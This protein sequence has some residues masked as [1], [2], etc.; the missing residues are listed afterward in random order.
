[1]PLRRL[2]RSHGLRAARVAELRPEEQEK[3]ENECRQ[4]QP[5]AVAES[6]GQVFPPAHLYESRHLR[7]VIYGAPFF[8]VYGSRVSRNDHLSP[9]RTLQM[10][11]EAKR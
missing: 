6:G 7:C 10:P 2:A 9:V 8:F 11:D 5:D 1:M 4:E 3:T